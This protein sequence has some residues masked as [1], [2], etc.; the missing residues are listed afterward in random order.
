MGLWVTFQ[1][2]TLAGSVN[3]CG[4]QS[5]GRRGYCSPLTGVV[6][7]AATVLS[8]ITSVLLFHLARA[9][10]FLPPCEGL[11]GALQACRI[12]GEDGSAVM[13]FAV[14]HARWLEGRSEL[15]GL[16]ALLLRAMGNG[17]ES[18]RYFWQRSH[19]QV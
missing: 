1:I 12:M 16:V 3:L 2:Q 8:G 9:L 18:Q 10:Q 14:G 15:T 19:G 4:R 11:L 6:Y 13:L 7:D 5:F 17:R